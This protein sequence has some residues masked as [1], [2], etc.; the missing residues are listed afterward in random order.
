MALSLAAGD[1]F[2]FAVGG[3]VPDMETCIMLSGGTRAPGDEG[4][5]PYVAD[6][7]VPVDVWRLPSAQERAILWSQAAPPAHRGIGVARILSPAMVRLCQAQDRLFSRTD[8]AA[9][10]DHPLTRLVLEMIARRGIPVRQPHSAR[11]GRDE[12]GRL[13]MT[14]AVHENARVGLHF[15]RWDALPLEDLDTATNRIL[16]NLGPSDRYFLC[17]NH[18]AANMAFL[19]RQAGMEM[20]PDVESVGK[21]FLASFP[22]YPVM[23]LR[24]RPGEAYIAPTENILHDGSSAGVDN[25]NTYLSIRGRLDFAP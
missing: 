21:A 3:G 19:L 8:D 5:P 9:T 15:D 14:M 13:T 18:S 7:R 17:I 4:A 6:A 10:L 12:P 20:P 2:L 11:K 22:D 25:A 23:R 1:V 16:I 24:L